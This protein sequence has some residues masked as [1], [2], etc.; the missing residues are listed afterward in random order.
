M[1]TTSSSDDE[2]FSDGVVSS[3]DSDSSEYSFSSVESD[4][5]Q[6]KF[7]AHLPATIVAY[8]KSKSGKST[9]VVDLILGRHLDP[10]PE[11][12][13]LLLN[14]QTAQEIKNKMNPIL[15]AIRATYP[16]EVYAKKDFVINCAGFGE[17]AEKL[18][19]VDSDLANK[20][21]IKFIIIEDMITS[22]ATKEIQDLMAKVSHHQNAGLYI[23]T[24]VIFPKAG[25]HMRDNAD[26][27]VIFPGFN[28]LS[29][30]MN[31]FAPSVSEAVIE[32]LS[33]ESQHAVY[34]SLPSEGK[35]QVRTPVIIDKS[36][37]DGAVPQ[38]TIWL[39]LDD[40][41][42]LSTSAEGRSGK[43]YKTNSTLAQHLVNEKLS[44]VSVK[45]KRGGSGQRKKSK[46]ADTVGEGLV[47][48]ITGDTLKQTSQANNA[49]SV[50]PTDFLP[51]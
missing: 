37:H 41:D 43:Q 50:I 31:N 9:F 8:G 40:I 20:M 17:L 32:R 30:F 33:P 1:T 26:I 21:K 51:E 2:Y 48:G 28:D 22:S 6:H 18:A 10:M 27:I 46:I 13:F 3:D 24:Q 12:Y 36:I 39:G 38:I 5:S 15:S 35:F 19:S 34:E 7:I 29:R 49:G 25:S 42:P 16:P 11:Q 44:D 45:R 4:M 23:S 14:A 47:G